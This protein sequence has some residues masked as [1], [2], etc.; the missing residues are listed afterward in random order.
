MVK[1]RFRQKSILTLVC[2]AAVC[3]SCATMKGRVVAHPEPEPLPYGYVTSDYDH[4]SAQ[5]VGDDGRFTLTGGTEK[6]GI[7]VGEY[8]LSACTFA[9]KDEN[10]AT[11]EIIGNGETSRTVLKISPG[12]TAA[13][14]FGPPLTASISASK[15]GGSYSLGINITGKGGETYQVSEFRQSGRRAAPPR[16]EVHNDAGEVI[17]RGRFQY[18]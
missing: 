18:G 10:G 7:P 3:T 2:I 4:F 11:W 9:A 13:V 17:A 12:E 6:V 14:P 15:Q 8:R 1:E 5:L 16:F